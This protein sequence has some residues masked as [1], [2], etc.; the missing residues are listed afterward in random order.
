MLIPFVFE[1]RALMDWVW[2]DTSMSLND[3]LTLEDIFAHI[4]QLKVLA[5]LFHSNLTNK[6]LKLKKYR[7]PLLL[8]YPVPI[9]L[10]LMF[11]QGVD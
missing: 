5:L 11:F 1:L 2:T 3:W 8:L 7:S 10:N 4:F 9:D 6:L